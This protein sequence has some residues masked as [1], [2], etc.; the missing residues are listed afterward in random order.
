[1]LTQLPAKRRLAALAAT[2]AALVALGLQPALASEGA[3]VVVGSGGISPGLGLNQEN[4]AVSFGGT[5]VLAGVDPAD[6]AIATCN[7][8]GGSTATETVISGT[9]LV[10]GTCST[11]DGRSG[12]CNNVR[13]YRVGPHVGIS[14]TCSGY[15]SGNLGGIFNFVPTSVSPVQSYQLQGV[16]VLSSTVD[17]GDPVDLLGGTLTGALDDIP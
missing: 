16:V 12:S 9:G 2:I 3:G 14:G 5:A 1:M 8:T 13:Y 15:V 10:S 6:A 11:D 7:F 17:P 4:Q